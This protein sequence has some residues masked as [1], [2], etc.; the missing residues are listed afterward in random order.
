MAFIAISRRDGHWRL[1]AQ[2]CCGVDAH[3]REYEHAFMEQV[4]AEGGRVVD[5][6]GQTVHLVDRRGRAHTVTL[7]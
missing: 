5:R 2:G 7:A 3:R 6:E 4:L 1:E